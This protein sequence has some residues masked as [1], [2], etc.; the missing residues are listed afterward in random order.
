MP[1]GDV[2][3]QAESPPEICWEFGRFDVGRYD[4]GWLCWR[5]G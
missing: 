5:W 1:L 4:D 2:K 3:R